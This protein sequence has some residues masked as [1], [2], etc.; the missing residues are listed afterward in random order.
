MVFL[1]MI[2]VQ[3]L[4]LV[5]LHDIVTVSYKAYFKEIIFPFA[6]VVLFSI[7][8]PYIPYY[9][10]HESF[11]RFVLVTF[12]AIVSIICALYYV[13][14]NISER[15]LINQLIFKIRKNNK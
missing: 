6:Y 3:Y 1:F 14:L 7:W 15:Q 11:I 12:I 9:Y 4:S 2:I 13:G 5:I 10:M 8:F